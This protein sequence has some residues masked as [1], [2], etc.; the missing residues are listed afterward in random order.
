MADRSLNRTL[1]SNE[2]G[3]LAGRVWTILRAMQEPFTP[4]HDQAPD[5]DGKVFEAWIAAVAKKDKSAFESLY[6][7]TVQR[8]YG[9]A[10]RITRSPDLTAEVIGDVYLQVWQQAS[11]YDPD[12]GEV[13]AWLTI[14]CRSRALDAVRR[15]SKAAAF[16]TPLEREQIEDCCD[17]SALELLA[18][19]EEKS[20]LH[21][22]LLRLKDEQ[23][24]LLALAYFKGYTRSELARC[25]G[26]P[27][28][29]VKTQLR[30]AVTALKRFVADNAGTRQD[31]NDSP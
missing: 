1:A 2:A 30:R 22:A 23:R 17:P 18:A 29:T 11:H 19:M 14:V 25:T 5:A 12:R 28:G 20:A 21:A 13:L 24:Q 3:F 9:L 27:L 16:E 10:L 4:Q 31:R 7:A 6:R 8:L 15:L 26:L